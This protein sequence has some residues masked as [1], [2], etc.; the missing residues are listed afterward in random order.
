MTRIQLTTEISAPI[1]TC[2][3]VSRDIDIH[4][5][6][7]EGTNEKAIAG[8]TSG[9][10]EQGDQVT[11]EAKHFG[12]KQQL[13]VQIVKVE[14]PL[15]FEDR[16]LKGAFKS[17]RHEHHF[18]EKDGKTIMSDLFEYEVPFGIF[19]NIFDKLILKNYM[20]RFLKIRNRVLKS[21]AEKTYNTQHP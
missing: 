14:R 4:Q 6:S 1:E 20:N 11:W 8:R 9:L 13:T 12:I 16:M 17:M 3:D 18:E 19:G 21:V 2:F 15:Y 5:L 10:C 7:T